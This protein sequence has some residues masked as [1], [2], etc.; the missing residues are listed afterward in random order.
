M[1]KKFILNIVLNLAIFFL[2]LSAVAAYNSGNVLYLGL[3]IAI[4]VVMVYF[5]VVLIK[6]VRREVRAK[7]EADSKNRKVNKKVDKVDKVNKG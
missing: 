5:K 2:I 7:Y 6:Q 3:S 4:L 1:T